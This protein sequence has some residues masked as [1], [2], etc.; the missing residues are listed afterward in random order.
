M[1]YW[2]CLQEY[3]QDKP[4]ETV[5]EE[6]A[7]VATQNLTQISK[8]QERRKLPEDTQHYKK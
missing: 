3:Q 5:K 7:Q 6:T 1:Q 2:P 4:S 8:E